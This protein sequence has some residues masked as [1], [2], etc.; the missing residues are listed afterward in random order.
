MVEQQQPEAQQEAVVDE[1]GTNS[2]GG[3]QIT[4]LNGTKENCIESVNYY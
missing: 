2:F 4:W 1:T 3:G